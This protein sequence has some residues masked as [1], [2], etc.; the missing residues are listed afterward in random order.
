MS[1]ALLVCQRREVDIGGG[2]V[3][4]VVGQGQQRDLCHHLHDLAIAETSLA[5]CGDLIVI[6][7]A[8]AFG[9]LM[10]QRG[11]RAERATTRLANGLIAQAGFGT[12][13]LCAAR[14]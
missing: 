12:K 13:K 7:L 8:A 5:C 9:D 11:D 2:D 1:V 14:Q 6:Q 10:R 4:Q 3:V